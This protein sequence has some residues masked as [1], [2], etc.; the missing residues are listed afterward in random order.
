MVIWQF[1]IN[2]DNSMQLQIMPSK[3]RLKFFEI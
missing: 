1:D 3:V 2:F